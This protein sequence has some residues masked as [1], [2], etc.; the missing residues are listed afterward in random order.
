MD[1]PQSRAFVKAFTEAYGRTPTD[2]GMQAYDTALLIAS[3][4]KAVNG[5]LSKGDAFRR[6]WP[7]PTSRRCG[8]SSASTPTGIPSRTTT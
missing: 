8:A 1:N 6:R 5:D 4:L 7:R 2:Y 3:A